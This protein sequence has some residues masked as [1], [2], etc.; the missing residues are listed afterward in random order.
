MRNVFLST[1]VFL[2]LLL[3]SCSKEDSVELENYNSTSVLDKGIESNED[4]RNLDFEQIGIHHN[5]GL[6]IFMNN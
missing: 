4:L 2:G 5:E 6:S 3:G 1:M